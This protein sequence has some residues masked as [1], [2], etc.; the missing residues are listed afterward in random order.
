MPPP[1]GRSLVIGER[2]LTVSA[3][4]IATNR[5]GDL[6]PLDFTPMG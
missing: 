5:L 3:T 4:G 6:A 1:I 2:L